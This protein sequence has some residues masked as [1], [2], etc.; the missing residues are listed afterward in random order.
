MF[1]IFNQFVADLL[2]LDFKLEDENLA[3]ML[4]SS[5]PDEFE[6]LETTL[7]HGKKNVSLDVVCSA[8]YSHELEKRDKMKTKS[9]TSETL[10]MLKASF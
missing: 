3:L 7:L 1:N 10:V 9:T 4:L 6:D 2:N 8:L 5:L